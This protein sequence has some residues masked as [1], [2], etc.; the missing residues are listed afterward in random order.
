VIDV[1]RD[2]DVRREL[3]GIAQDL[4]NE[5]APLSVERGVLPV[6]VDALEKLVLRPI[7]GSSANYRV[8]AAEQKKLRRNG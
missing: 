1:P 3:R 2:D 7:A 6:V 8:E 5:H 4:R